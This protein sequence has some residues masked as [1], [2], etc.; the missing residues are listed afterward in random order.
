MNVLFK[1]LYKI[2][3]QIIKKNKKTINNKYIYTFD[4]IIRAF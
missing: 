4:K 3:N 2:K 1:F